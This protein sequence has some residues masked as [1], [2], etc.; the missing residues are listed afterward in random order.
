MNKVALA[1]ISLLVQS[2]VALA[3]E[4]DKAGIS[5][6][7][8]PKDEVIVYEYKPRQEEP[9]VFEYLE[10]DRVL[11]SSY[12]EATGDLVILRSIE[13]GLVSLEIDGK[14]VMQLLPLCQKC[15]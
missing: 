1:V 5:F 7:F 11:V 6:N 2:S 12:H 4:T 13:N 10:A 14:E 15:K 9:I 8:R 3:G